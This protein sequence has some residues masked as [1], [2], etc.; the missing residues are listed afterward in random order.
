MSEIVDRVLGNYEKALELNAVQILESRERVTQYIKMMMS[1]GQTDPNELTECAFA[2]LKEMHEGRDP[3]F[4]AR[5]CG[6]R[7]ATPLNATT[8]RRRWSTQPPVTSAISCDCSSSLDLSAQYRKST[9]LPAV[10]RFATLQSG[11]CRP[12]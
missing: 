8:S 10:F 11:D 3:R 5:G 9:E 1:A 7:G 12:A 6:S 2:Y 4:T